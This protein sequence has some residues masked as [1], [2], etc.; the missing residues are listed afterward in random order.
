MAVKVEPTPTARDA[1]AQQFGQL[2]GEGQAE[3][4][5]LDLLL[6]PVLDLGELLEDQFLILGGDADAGVVDG[7]GDRSLVH[8][9]GSRDADLPRSVYL[10]A[11]EMKLRRICDTLPS[12][13]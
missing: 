13:V 10:R 4:G 5:A 12:S 6:E 8:V 9:G 1:A 2:L 3:T 7:K 11:L